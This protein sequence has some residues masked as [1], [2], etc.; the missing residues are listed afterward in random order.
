MRHDKHVVRHSQSRLVF[1][2][3]RCL[4]A[5]TEL[6]RCHTRWIHVCPLHGRSIGPC[7]CCVVQC[8]Q[9]A[10]EKVI[11]TRRTC[12]ASLSYK[13]LQG[14]CVRVRAVPMPQRDAVC[15]VRSSAG[16]NSSAAV[17]LKSDGRCAYVA[18]LIPFCS[19]SS[20]SKNFT[21]SVNR[22]TN[23]SNC[24][25]TKKLMSFNCTRQKSE[26]F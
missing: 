3:I 8:Y 11:I 4:A 25:S 16:L 12:Y 20:L 23:H 1:L 2:F 7:L 24:L 14:V 6:C 17:H 13:S 22:G 15:R 10:Q 5:Q 21:S 26:T 19:I 9:M 18:C